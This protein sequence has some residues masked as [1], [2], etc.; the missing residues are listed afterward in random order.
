VQS[1]RAPIRSIDVAPAAAMSA[2][3]GAS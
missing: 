3:T 2:G 1:T